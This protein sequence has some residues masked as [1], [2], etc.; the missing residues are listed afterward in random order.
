MGGASIARGCG[1]QFRWSSVAS[2]RE[3]LSEISA[4]ENG[5]LTYD[6]V[7]FAGYFVRVKA[8]SE[9]DKLMPYAIQNIFIL[10][11][12][13]LF[14]A[15][16]YM[17]LSRL[18]RAVGGDMHSLVPVP[19]LT[20]IF[21]GGDV[22]SFM[23]QGG[24]SGLMASGTAAEL[25]QWIVVAGLLI[26]IAM[27][28]FFIVTTVVFHHRASAAPLSATFAFHAARPVLYMLYAVSGLIMGR[29]V[30]R[31]IEFVMGNDGYPLE[32][33]WTLY[34]FDSIP[35]VAVMGIYYI[36]YPDWSDL[37]EARHARVNSEEVMCG[38]GVNLPELVDQRV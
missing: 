34:V 20:K 7:E 6:E 36:W 37:K 33:E 19:W 12:P 21:V 28:G 22:V 13:V 3:P 23:V 30:F 24:A 27:F 9:T 14:A 31:V 1:L 15:S 38:S 5:E 26:Q 18:V 17:I 2:V 29:S 10:L 11:P 4:F 35:M 16:I 8:S 32:H 25:A